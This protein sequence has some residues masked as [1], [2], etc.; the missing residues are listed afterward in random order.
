LK[1]EPKVAVLVLNY[2]GCHHLDEC[3]RSLQVQDYG[4]YEVYV[5][6]NASVDGSVEYVRGS[7]PWVKIIAFDENF[8]F[9]KAYNKA[10]RRV[11]S[12]LIAFLNNDT[13][14]E[15]D[16]LKELVLC[17]LEEASVVAVGSKMLLY[18]NPALLNH[19]GTKITQIGGGF[20]IGAYEKDTLKYNVKKIVG[21]VCG[22]AMIVR[23]YSFLENGCFDEDFFAYFEDVDL[24][25]RFWLCGFKVM[26]CP[27]SVVYHK[28]GSSWGPRN[29]PFRLLQ[30]QRNRLIAM[31][32]NLEFRN[33]LFGLII[34]FLYDFIEVLFL[35][36]R[37]DIKCIKMKVKAYCWVANNLGF[38]LQKRL[39]IQRNRLVSD[40]W[41]LNAG[42][43]ASF[44]EAIRE[45]MRLRKL[46]QLFFKKNYAR[47]NSEK[48]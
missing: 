39:V 15:E 25:W 20:S 23:K 10:V 19:A 21:A 11:N 35:V 34:A 40:K 38:I 22:G 2:N 7:F 32:K 28:L 37:K 6:D 24:C 3:L 31:I 8:G 45:Y 4:N 42:L 30:G 47:D 26:Y 14:V 33:V 12:E 9:S 13:K 29:N 44:K 5:V 27:A 46:G 48:Q 17:M 1:T 36:N 18:G 43:M 16:W 41:L